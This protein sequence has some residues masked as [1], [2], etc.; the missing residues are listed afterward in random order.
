MSPWRPEDIRMSDVPPR[1]SG[2]TAIRQP[3]GPAARRSESLNRIQTVSPVVQSV[4]SRSTPLMNAAAQ[5]HSRI[6]EAWFPRAGT[7]ASCLV[8][9]FAESAWLARPHRSQHPGSRHLL[10]RF[11]SFCRNRMRPSQ[12]PNSSNIRPVRAGLVLGLQSRSGDGR[13]EPFFGPISSSQT[14]RTVR[15]GRSGDYYPAKE[16]GQAFQ[17][18]KAQSQAGKPDYMRFFRAGLI[19][20]IQNSTRR[21]ISCVAKRFAR[22]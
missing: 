19:V 2:I 8:C 6:L 7:L 11:S 14:T 12:Y 17:P 3:P 21:I 20:E 5:A 1:I 18:D 4:L 10:I 9:H 13:R 15:F 16:V 22:S